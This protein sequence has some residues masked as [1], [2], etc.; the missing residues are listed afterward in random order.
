MENAALD[1]TG[2]AYV[3]GDCDR[4]SDMREDAPAIAALRGAPDARAVVIARDQAVLR[5]EGESAAALHGIDQAAAIGAVRLEAFLGLTPAGAPRFAFWLDD[6]AVEMREDASDG[7]LDRRALVVPGRTDL[8]LADL[9]SLAMKGA[10]D[11]PTLSMIAT[12]KALISWH[13]THGFC[14]KCGAKSHAAAAGWRRECAACQTQHFPR[15][16]PVV[17]MLVSDGDHCLLG[18]QARFPK[19]FYS[20][21]AGFL[22]PGETIEAAVKREVLE[23]AG[24][25][26][27]DVRYLASQPWP[28]PAS[29]MIGCFASASDRA[30]TIDHKELE[31]ARWFSRAEVRQMLAGDHPDGLASP[32]KMAIA[33]TLLQTWS[34][35]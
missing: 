32:G 18:R 30:L 9:R 11:P 12:A 10:F 28:F 25:L 17:I 22:E 3:S 27:R 1:A 29:L 34:D 8:R 33:R 14:A 13:A 16:D 21:L 19:G 7:F 5:G 6:G 23:E 4:R 24:V 35:A 20:A 15:T 31:D 26:C 2:M